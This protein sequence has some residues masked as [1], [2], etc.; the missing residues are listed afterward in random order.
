M[1]CNLLIV[2]AWFQLSATLDFDEK[3]KIRNV[4]RE[5][6]RP[7]ELG[8]Q[9]PITALGVS[10]A[11]CSCRGSVKTVWLEHFVTVKAE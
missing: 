5:L 6:R 11:S 2:F 8:K 4:I 1:L 10:G 3:R 7:G 9:T